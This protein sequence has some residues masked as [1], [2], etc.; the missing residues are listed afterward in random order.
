MAIFHP[1]Q[2]PHPLT[3][4]QKIGTGDYVGGPTAAPNLVQILRLAAFAQMGEI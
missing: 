3:D 4:R 1:P 2:N